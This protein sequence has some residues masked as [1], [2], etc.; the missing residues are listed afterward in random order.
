MLDFYVFYNFKD[1]SDKM[2]FDG[3]EKVKSWDKVQALDWFNMKHNRN[4]FIEIK[5]ICNT[6]EYNAIIKNK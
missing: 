3:V 2:D 5:R 4:G 6:I 1:E